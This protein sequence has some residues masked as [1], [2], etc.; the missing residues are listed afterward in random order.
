[1][2]NILSLIFIALC[3]VAPVTSFAA[4][5]QVTVYPDTNK[6]DIISTSVADTI[7]VILDNLSTIEI[8]DFYLT[9]NSDNSVFVLETNV[10]GITDPLIEYEI[11]DGAIY[12]NQFSTTF[13]IGNF[14][15]TTS[16]KF[17]TLN[18]NSLHITFCGKQPFAFFGIIE[19]I[20]SNCC[21]GMRGNMNGDSQDII[22]VSDLVYIINYS[23]GNPSGPPPP[24]F[25]EAD[26]NV[27]GTLDISDIVYLVNYMFSLEDNI[28]PADCP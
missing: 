26:V 24:C 21:I 16:L 25:D 7:N 3:C 9:V 5:F 27:S 10:D 28:P 12:P 6:V 13:I 1:M 8:T 17:Y 22:N 2:K 15:Q 14:T 11:F 23:F 4:D 20:V 19:P 18:S